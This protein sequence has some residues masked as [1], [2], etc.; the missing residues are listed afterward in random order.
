ML[1]ISKE[2]LTCLSEPNASFVLQEYIDTSA[3]VRKVHVVVPT[4]LQHNY[5]GVS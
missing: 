1:D 5:K 3:G 2:F 4:W